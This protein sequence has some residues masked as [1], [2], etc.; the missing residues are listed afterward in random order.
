MARIVQLSAIAS[1]EVAAWR[2]D[3]P[4]SAHRAH[5]NNAGA[6]LCPW[7][8]L[9]AVHR[10]LALEAEI[11]GY[12]AAAAAAPAIEQ[13]YAD[14][15]EL[16]G[17][18]A[19]E[20]AVLS[21]ATHA[22]SQAM[23]AFDFSPGDVIV[24]SNGDYISNQLMFLSLAARRGVRVERAS[25]L[26]EGGID[27]QCVRELVRRHRP[28]LVALSWVPTSSGLIQDAAGVGAACEDGG[29]PFLLDAC[30]AVG[31]L[32]VDVTALRC[33]FLAATAR[34][35]LRG[36]R[37][38]GFLYVS[39]RALERGSH[40]L[41]VDMRGARWTETDAFALFDGA[42]RFEQWEV[43]Y[44]LLLGMGAAARYALDTGVERTSARAHELA[45]DARVRL[46][47]IPG[48]RSL[49]RGSRLSAIATFEPA[50][51]DG[52]SLV[53]ALRERGINTSA[54]ARGDALIDLERQQARSLL[55]VS[56]H[57]YNTGAEI[58]ALE[59]ALRS[60]LA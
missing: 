28:R 34:K 53:A 36:P 10:H 58:D 26:V 1:D 6:A 54:Q 18:R 9:N 48:L 50:G 57:Y 25:D 51:R 46:S 14:V 55:R 3:T 21:S 11:G 17:A 37:G 45:A 29:V 32:P 13:T 8:V 23:S 42:R 41:L 33:D 43:P 27:P 5:L 44:A 35:F 15:A 31:Q 60:L 19:N 7:P 30:Q 47:A 59:S 52:A 49:D 16:V 39:S 24:T 56:P 20:I 12:E 40:P 2:R 38:I 22:F 4:G